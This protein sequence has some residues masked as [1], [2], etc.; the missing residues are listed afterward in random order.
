MLLV[1]NLPLAGLWA[2]LLF[3]PQQ[4]LYAGILVFAV[5]GVYGVSRS[6]FDLAVLG[7]FG[8]LGYAMRRLDFPLAPVIVGMILGPMA[9]VQ[10]RRA[11][12]IT[13]GDL[14][15]F[16]TRPISLTLLL[17]AAAVL[18]APLIATLFRNLRR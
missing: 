2:R 14:S 11:I 18:F 17:I 4:W 15:V 13:Q 7:A 9:E 1:L 10:F 16:V 6:G 5:L 8:L 12:Q 3:I